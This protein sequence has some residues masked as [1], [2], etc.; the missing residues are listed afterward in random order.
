MMPFFIRVSPEYSDYTYESEFKYVL[1][2]K[3][4]KILSLLSK[5][6]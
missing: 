4:L 6:D 2:Q 3:H 5:N 1:M